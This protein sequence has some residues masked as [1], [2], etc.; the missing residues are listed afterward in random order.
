MVTGCSVD[1]GGFDLAPP[2]D[3]DPPELAVPCAWPAGY[4]VTQ[5]CVH[6]HVTDSFTCAEHLDMM[7]I[8]AARAMALRT[9]LADGPAAHVPGT[10]GRLIAGGGMTATLTATGGA[11]TSGQRRTPVPVDL[12]LPRWSPLLSVAAQDYGSE[13]WG[14]E[15]SERASLT[16]GNAASYRGVTLRR[17]LRDRNRDCNA[18]RS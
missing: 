9:M 18:E 17:S 5:A 13:G 2:D 3:L 14:F 6:E 12:V 1:W 8:S 7:R 15:S 11:D 4:R 16:S 10:G